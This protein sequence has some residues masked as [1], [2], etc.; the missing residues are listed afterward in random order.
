MQPVVFGPSD[1][2]IRPLVDVR[3][4]HRVR[5][6]R[7]VLATPPEGGGVSHVLAEAGG[8]H[9]GAAAARGGG[10]GGEGGGGDG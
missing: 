9:G 10:D 7:G 1:E 5:A 6:V 2:A 4:G 8:R 3:A